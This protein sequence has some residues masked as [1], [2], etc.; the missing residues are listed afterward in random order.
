MHERVCTDIKI[1]LIGETSSREIYGSALH[2]TK[3]TF[4]RRR[5]HL[6]PLLKEC[7][8]EAVPRVEGVGLVT[9]HQL[10]H[11]FQDDTQLRREGK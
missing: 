11:R 7:G 4:T 2:L 10:L 6:L 3:L 1:R 9:G 8:L 5:D